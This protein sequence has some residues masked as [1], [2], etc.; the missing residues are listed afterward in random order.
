M[1][2]S[3]SI[4]KDGTMKF[5][6]ARKFTLAPNLLIGSQEGKALL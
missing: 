4:I 2:G 3:L 1:N 5:T 6:T